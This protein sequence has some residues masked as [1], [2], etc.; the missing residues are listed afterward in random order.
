MGCVA[1]AD[2]ARSQ[3]YGNGRSNSTG[4]PMI[5]FYRV[6]PL[7]WFLGRRLVRVPHLTMV[8]L[9]AGRRVVP[10]FMQDEATGERLATAAVSLLRDEALR[11]E[12][13]REL[14][15]VAASLSGPDDPMERAARIVNSYLDA[16][17]A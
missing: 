5:T 15:L 6:S 7:S 2:I 11:N 17:D 9:V 1:H 16:N 13:K 4:T 10:E 3:R 8:N 14:A 12:M